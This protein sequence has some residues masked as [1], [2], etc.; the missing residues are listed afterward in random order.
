MSKFVDKLIDGAASAALGVTVIGAA[1]MAVT[2][3]AGMG[4]IAA[5]SA[6][7]LAANSIPVVGKYLRKI[8]KAGVEAADDQ[9]VTTEYLA[10]ETCM[11]AGA[12]LLIAATVLTP[13][14]VAVAPVTSVIVA[15]G[16]VVSM[17]LKIVGMGRKETAK[18]KRCG[19]G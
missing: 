3:V 18:R 15:W 14:V 11:S 9:V 13:A 4:F 1:A 16:P 12:A 10:L 17:L 6:V 8:T 7:M 19:L 5:G 2:G